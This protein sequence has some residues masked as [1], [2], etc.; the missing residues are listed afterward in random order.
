[1]A[2]RLTI[3]VPGPAYA[4]SDGTAQEDAVDGPGTGP[5]A[6]AIAGLRQQLEIANRR[7]DELTAERQQFTAQ[8]EQERVRA[9]RAEEK[10][11][12]LQAELKT[13]EK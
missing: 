10:A 6:Q 8:T 12:A 11:T 2:E 13:G 7:I 9:D 1:M 5:M 3:D 4:M